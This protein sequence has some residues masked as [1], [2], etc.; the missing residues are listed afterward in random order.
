MFFKWL[1]IGFALCSTPNNFSVKRTCFYITKQHLNLE[2]KSSI[3]IKEP[4]NIT[5]NS[6]TKICPEISFPH[7]SL[8][9]KPDC[10][11]SRKRASQ[12]K[13][14]FREMEISKKDNIQQDSSCRTS[15]EDAIYF[16]TFC[17][18]LGLLSNKINTQTKK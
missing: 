11:F 12:P 10:M 7:N 5:W 1:L 18:W 14:T 9:E 4:K 2:C 15:K 6:D 16:K 8:A 13:I 17:V 3:L